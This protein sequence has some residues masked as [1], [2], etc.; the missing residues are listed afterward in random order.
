MSVHLLKLA[1]GIET[2]DHLRERQ[3]QRIAEQKAAGNAPVL[4]ILTRNTPRRADELTAESGSLF[5]VIKG[6]ILVRQKITSVEPA[7]GHDGA[8]SCAIH[9]GRK[10]IRV[11]PRR[12]RPFQGWR[13]LEPDNAPLDLAAGAAAEAEPPAEMAEELRELGLI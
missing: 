12:S 8:P 10:I 5:W 11:Q 4:R 3:K 6:R 1:V 13:Y 2:I 7:T 9:L